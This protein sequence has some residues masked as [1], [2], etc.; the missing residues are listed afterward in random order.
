MAPLVCRRDD[1]PRWFAP[2][3]DMFIGSLHSMRPAHGARLVSM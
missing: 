2:G 3:F 1:V